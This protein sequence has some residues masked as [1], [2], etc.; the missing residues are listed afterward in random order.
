LA[1]IFIVISWLSLPSPTLLNHVLYYSHFM[2]TLFKTIF[3]MIFL[4]RKT[5]KSP[6]FASFFGF[7]NLFLQEL[8]KNLIARL[9]E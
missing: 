6:Q 8:Y 2:S 9:G 4:N 7:G 1:N 5:K 3:L